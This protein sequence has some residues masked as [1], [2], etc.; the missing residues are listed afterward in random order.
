MKFEESSDSL[1]TIHVAAAVIYSLR[2]GVPCIFATQRGYGKWKD[3]WE[4]PGGKLESGESSE[5]AVVREIQ[6]ELKAFISV[7]RMID[8]VEWDY[9]EFHLVMDCF[10]CCVK[11]GNLTL[12]EHE[13]SRWLSEKE[14]DSVNWLPADKL[15]LPKITESLKNI[16]DS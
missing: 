7:E 6:E 5:V 9:P 8:T 3:W 11:S 13:D 14:I 2:D 12:L 15:L 10:L 16:V 1:K 4:F